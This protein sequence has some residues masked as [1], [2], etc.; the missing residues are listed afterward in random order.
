MTALYFAKAYIFGFIQHQT[1][2]FMTNH[3]FSMFNNTN[4]PSLDILDHSYISKCHKHDKNIQNGRLKIAE[5][6]IFCFIQPK[7]LIVVSNHRFS[8]SRNPNMHSI[9]ILDHWYISKF[10]L[11]MPFLCHLEI[12]EW[13]KMFR[14]IIY[15]FH[16]LEN[17]CFGTTF[18]VLW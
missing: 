7:T 6:D 5:D 15:E 1:L 11:F 13:S 8:R 2:I 16:V 17:R 9:N 10:V 12:Y 18:N 14:N 3:R 4:M